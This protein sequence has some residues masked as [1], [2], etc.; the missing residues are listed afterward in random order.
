MKNDLSASEAAAILEISLATLYSYVSR[1]LLSSKKS[2]DSHRKHYDRQEVMHLAARRGDAK[3]GGHLA[4]SAMNWGIPILETRISHI[5]DGKLLYRGYDASDLAQHDTLEAVACLLWDDS[6]QDYF[7]S[8]SNALPTSIV[9]QA[10]ALLAMTNSASILQRAMALTSILCAAQLRQHQTIKANAG[11]VE[12]GEDFQIAPHLLRQLTAIFLE[13]PLSDCPIHQQIAQAWHCDAMQTELIR[14]I[15]VLLADH[16]L[17]A[18]T[19]AVRCVASTGADLAAVLCTGLAALSGHLHGAGSANAKLMLTE[20]LKT[21]SLTDF[22]QHYFVN[23]NPALYGFGHPL[24]PDG[25]PRAAFLLHR[26]TELA[27]ADQ[28]LKPALEVCAA[29]S[30]ILNTPPNI[31]MLIACME[32]SYAWPDSAGIMLFA[33]ARCT[34]WIAHAHEQKHTGTMIRPR[35][36]YVGKYRF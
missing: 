10:F 3:H 12:G 31:D 19:F 9:D 29:T 8:A 4:A 22:V 6:K 27:K 17:N 1:G 28:R 7:A 21:P 34:G 32:T 5:V 20:A 16:E 15:L 25:D 36:R 24:Y 23:L 26:L 2:S 13:I 35:A 33:I 14:H 30:K 11:C 18:S